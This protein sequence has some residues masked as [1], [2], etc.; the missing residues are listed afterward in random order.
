MTTHKTNKN[1]DNF[2]VPYS[3]EAERSVLGAL[4]LNSNMFFDEVNVTLHANDFYDEKHKIIYLFIK[5]F[6]DDNSPCDIIILSDKLKAENLLDKIGGLHYLAEII[7]ETPV[8]SN[9]VAYANIV[10]QKSFLRYYLEMC[11]NIL[12]KIYANDYAST[13]DLI[14][15]VENALMQASKISDKNKDA[16][17]FEDIKSAM[18]AKIEEMIEN[19]KSITG[20]ATGFKQL[21]LLTRGLQKGE[22]FILAARPSMGKTTLAMNIAEYVS[23]N[24]REPVLV[25]SLEMDSQQLF[26]RLISSLSKVNL[27]NLITGKIGDNDC[28]RIFDTFN[29]KINILVDDDAMVSIKEIRIRARRQFKKYGGLSL[30]IVDYLQLIHGDTKKDRVNEVSE[31]SRAL[32]CL[33]KEL[34]VPIIALSQLS[35]KCEERPDKRPMMSDLRDSGAIEQDA[36][37]IGFIYRDEVYNKNT[38]DQG[39][40]ELLIKKHR[41]GALADIKLNFDAQHCKFKDYND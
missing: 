16:V 25:F 9:I 36:D 19:K 13:E 2:Q 1:T 14:D 6:L 33:A 30:I 23:E 7:Q 39:V 31:I 12:S 24:N 15:Y 35:R 20:I 18:I 38:F 40:A 17:L 28:A 22:L 10:K 32:K 5:K 34:G 27:G 21:D 11:G 26:Y 3:L 37:I 29:K 41:Q 4:L 8:A